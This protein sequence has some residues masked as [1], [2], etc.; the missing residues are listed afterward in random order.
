MSAV[1]LASCGLLGGY[2]VSAFQGQHSSRDLVQGLETVLPFLGLGLALFAFLLQQVRQRYL[3]LGSVWSLFILWS[4]LS[5]QFLA[6]LCSLLATLVASWTILMSRMRSESTGLG[7]LCLRL[8][9]WGLPGSLMFSVMVLAFYASG[10]D[11]ISLSSVWLVGF[12]LFWMTLSRDEGESLDVA[13]KQPWRQRLAVAICM[14]GGATF[15]FM[16]AGSKLAQDLA[17][18]LQVTHQE[19]QSPIQS[20]IEHRESTVEM[21]P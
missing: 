6:I 18:Y 11:G 17:P 8:G 2:F 7:D 12:F 10:A 16:P 20:P 19:A 15:A 14:L 1:R 9:V 21:P 5:G 4:A 13:V 3:I